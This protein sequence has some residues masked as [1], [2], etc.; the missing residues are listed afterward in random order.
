MNNK[1]LPPLPTPKFTKTIR[2]VPCITVTEHEYLMRAY[3]MQARA[4]VQGEP[5]GYIHHF[6]AHDD[7]GVIIDTTWE[8]DGCSDAMPHPTQPAAW[9]WSHATPFYTTP[10]PAQAAQ[11]EA[12][13]DEPV[14]EPRARVELMKTGG[15]A[16]L[17]TRI[18]E[19]DIATRERLR[20]GDL[21]YTHPAPGV[22]EGYVIAPIEPTDEMISAACQDGVSVDGRQV[23]KHSNAFQAKW[24][25]QQ[26]LTAAQA[27]KG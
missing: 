11:A 20:P 5:F 10:Q 25:Y 1:Q 8:A 27:Q 22:Q 23:W 6:V 15:N 2:G 13:T 26:M 9:K 17:S 12:K 24:K 21:L 7:S 18:I 14:G 4:Q 16:G 19:L 3:A